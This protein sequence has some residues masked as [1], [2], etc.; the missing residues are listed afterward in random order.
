MQNE[1]I[2]T[3]TEKIKSIIGSFEPSIGLILGSGLGN[4]A[5]EIS[6]PVKIKYKDIGFPVSTV[7][8]HIGQ[9]VVGE[10]Q[11]KKVIAMQGR[12]HF[13]E[14]HSLEDVT[15]PVRVMK[16]LGVQTL[17]ITNAAGGVNLAFKPGNLMVIS[18]HINFSGL[19]PLRGKNM[20]AFGVRF[21]DMTACYC[22]KLITIAM[23]TAKAQ[24]CVLQQGVY[25]FSS[26]PSYET[27]AE[28]LALRTLGISAIGMSTVPEAIVAS[29]SGM[30]VLGISCITNM[31]AGVLNQKLSH[32]EVMETTV[33][34]NEKFIRLLKGI[35]ERIS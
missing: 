22:P 7:E 32:A 20:D 19:N 11:G 30:Q 35:I 2:N 25:C 8:G 33:L 3:A 27:P 18:D 4:L 16:R 23:D 13:Y 14:G 26:G 17:I 28:I 1:R 34:V 6:A 29:H 24:N 9:L 12:S 10:L 21:P 31:A 5:D 15:L